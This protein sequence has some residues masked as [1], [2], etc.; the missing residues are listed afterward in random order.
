MLASA[1]RNVAGSERDG[2]SGG[3]LAPWSDRSPGRPLG[4]IEVG[5][6]DRDELLDRVITGV[7]EHAGAEHL[8]AHLA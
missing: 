3:E 5:D 6:E 7:I 1:L 2:E 4:A 8:S